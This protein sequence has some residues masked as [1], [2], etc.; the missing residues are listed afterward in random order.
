MG[1]KGL[2]KFF[3]SRFNRYI[4]YRLGWRMTFFYVALLGKLYYLLHM[5]ER[6]K[7]TNAVASVL[8]GHKTGAE[9][10]S[11]TRSVFQGIFM[12]YYEKLF[13][14]F[15]S[16]GTLKTFLETHT[17]ERGLEA[18]REGLRKGNGVLLI[19]GHFGG[20]ELIPAFLGLNGCP[21]TIIARF[22][23]NNLRD[24]CIEKARHF[25]TRVIDA[26]ETPN[27]VKVI[28]KN[29]KA[30]RVVITLCDEI[31][32]WRPSKS[33]ETNFLG[34]R[35]KLDRTINVLC[36]RVKAA[37]VMGFMY[38]DPR[39]RYRFEAI[40]EDEIVRRTW[41]AGNLSLGTA[42]LRLMEGFIHKYPEN[43]YLWKKYPAIQTVQSPAI[44]EALPLATPAL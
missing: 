5:Q 22:A 19:T 17:A 3:Q 21:V 37:V 1:K 4:Y 14:A 16:W 36:K 10:K 35:I 18:V 29:L 7:I 20:V 23:D 11:I 34:K 15:S 44:P 9:I 30:N 28:S 43:W 31:D 32:E 24:A 27:V 41:P 38:R 2:S 40:P 25:Q 33:Q 12:H 42:V 8:E 6:N 39:H 26:G 13:N